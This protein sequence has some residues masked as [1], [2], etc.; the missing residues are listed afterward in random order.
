[1][2]KQK[3]I[4][5]VIFEYLRTI[6]WTIFGMLIVLIVLLTFIQHKIYSVNGNVE[7]QNDAEDQSYTVGVLIAKDTALAQQSPENYRL[8]LKLGILYMLTKDYANAEIQFKLAEE[9][10]PYGEYSPQY[11]LA[12][13][14]IVKN[15]LDD[16]QSIMDKISERPDKKLIEYK[17]DIYNRLGDAYY[18]LA[19][20]STAILKY[21]K[22]IFYFQIIK[23]KQLVDVKNSLASAY[24]YLAE[25]DVRAMQIQDAISSLQT[26]ITIVD[27]PILKYKLAI[28]LMKSNPDLSCKYFDEVYKKEPDII[29][30]DVYYNFLIAMSNA[31]EAGGNTTEKQLFDYRAKK[32]KEYYQ[33]NI[34]SITDISIENPHGVMVFNKWKSKY[35]IILE[36]QI[37]NISSEPFKSLF[38]DIIFK[39]DLGMITEYKN[40]IVDDKS[41]VEAGAFSPVISIKTSKAQKWGK[42][43]KE[44]LT[45]DIYVSKTEKSYKLYLKTVKI[46]EVQK[47]KNHVKKKK[48]VY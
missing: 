40:Q 21:E 47:D 6:A 29:D 4:R 23:S 27:A 45:A 22:S 1:M 26:A 34:L 11:N 5:E 17:G 44:N 41:S 39:D 20:Y 35:D 25:T 3:P 48:H 32:F 43:G 8:N 9:K 24:V 10:A 14:Y 30:F 31:S 42:G 16:A 13:L 33:K 46:E 37:K 19:D 18:N 28:L 15:K 38:V 12:K 36:F 2:N 7:A